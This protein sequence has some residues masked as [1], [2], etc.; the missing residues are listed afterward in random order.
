MTASVPSWSRSPRP[1]RTTSR[2]RAAAA[3]CCWQ[4]TTITSSLGLGEKGFGGRLSHGG[5]EPFYL[6]APEKERPNFKELRVDCDV[7]R[8]EFSGVGTKWYFAMKDETRTA[9]GRDY[10]MVKGQLL[11][12]ETLV[13]DRNGG[14]N[15]S[16]PCEVTL[17]D[18]E[19]SEG[20]ELPREIHVRYGND[21]YAIFKDVR[22]E[23]AK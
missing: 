18:Y 12:F 15:K 13:P 11:G 22:F 19:K 8:S 16:D 20:R 6:P 3:A 14:D 9:G 2:T 17:L 23:M 5:T 10:K 4:C 21:G 1:S 7:L